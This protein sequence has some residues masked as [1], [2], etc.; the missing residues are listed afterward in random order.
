MQYATWEMIQQLNAALRTGR[1]RDAGYVPCSMC[2]ELISPDASVCPFCG[3]PAGT[4]A[5]SWQLVE[6]VEKV[7]V[8][9]MGPNLG[10]PRGAGR[11]VKAVA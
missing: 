5:R 9:R 4:G 10:K 7:T 1:L 8:N 2:R 3:G 11:N 6:V